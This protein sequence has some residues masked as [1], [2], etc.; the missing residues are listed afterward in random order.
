LPAAESAFAALLLVTTTL[1][2]RSFIT[3]TRVDAGYH[4]ARRA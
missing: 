3:P 1:L 2:A 4:V